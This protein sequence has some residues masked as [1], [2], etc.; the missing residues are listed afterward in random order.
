MAAHNISFR[1][2][3]TLILEST[4]SLFADWTLDV[5]CANCGERRELPIADLPA[6]YDSQTIGWV[7]RH[8][9]CRIPRCGGRP[10]RLILRRGG[11]EVPLIGVGAYG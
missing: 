4:V 3:R 9:R 11:Y 1:K 8:L 6:R 7:M 2:R 5:T 10:A